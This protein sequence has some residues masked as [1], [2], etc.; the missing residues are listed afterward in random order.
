MWN[1]MELSFQHLLCSAVFFLSV[2]VVLALTSSTTF[3]CPFSMVWKLCC[4][5]FRSKSWLDLCCYLLELCWLKFQHLRMPSWL[6]PHIAP[7]QLLV[8]GR[9]LSRPLLLFAQWLSAFA[10]LVLRTQGVL[11]NIS[12]ACVRE[13]ARERA[14]ES[15]IEVLVVGDWLHNEIGGKVLKSF[16]SLI[17][18]L[19]WVTWAFI[20]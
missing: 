5:C 8:H 18:E 12:S 16:R 2:E 20:L 15:L 3:E 10:G 9:Q 17:T 19:S 13:R 1:G 7:Y 14:R 6:L 11:L 4:W